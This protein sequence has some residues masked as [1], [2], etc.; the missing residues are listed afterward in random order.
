MGI[1]DRDYYRE[2]HKHPK[3]N[4][5]I[6]SNTRNKIV[7][8]KRDIFTK[9]SVISLCLLILLQFLDS[10][11]S[12]FLTIT[13][14]LAFIV[15]SYKSW[16]WKY[17]SIRR[18]RKLVNSF[19]GAFI[20][21]LL[22]GIVPFDS[23]VGRILDLVTTILMSYVI[24]SFTY[25][26]MIFINNLDLRSDLNCWGIRILGVIF[27]IAGIIILS[28]NAIAAMLIQSETT[29]PYI[30]TIMGLCLL[31]LGIFSEFRAKRRY[32]IF[33]YLR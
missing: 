32:G 9:I 30:F 2:K 15:S 8:V 17:S 18:H 10:Y 6:R 22:T 24:I 11:N 28:A 26:S 33:V 1:E 29:A 21:L 12:E 13:L 7:H 4:N 25:I 3:R 23:S 14:L 20:L 16:I 5:Y 19:T 31:V 27:V